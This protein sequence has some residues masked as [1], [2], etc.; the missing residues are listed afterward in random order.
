MPPCQ[1][2]QP[3]NRT[4]AGRM[5]TS[6]GWALTPRPLNCRSDCRRRRRTSQ[7]IVFG[8]QPRRVSERVCTKSGTVLGILACCAQEKVSPRNCWCH[9]SPPSHRCYTFLTEQSSHQRLPARATQQEITRHIDTQHCLSG[10]P[11]ACTHHRQMRAHELEQ[12]RR[13][14]SLPGRLRPIQLDVHF[15][16]SP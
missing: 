9:H 14:P 4:G 16:Q 15:A 13:I 12:R 1:L 11:P 6:G 7:E 10:P 2:Y 5:H 3:S 8:L